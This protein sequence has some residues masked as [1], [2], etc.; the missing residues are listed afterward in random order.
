MSKK[1]FRFQKNSQGG[2]D[3][4]WKDDQGKLYIG[5]NKDTA[6]P[7]STLYSF[8]HATTRD[9]YRDGKPVWKL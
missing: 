8:G 9:Y 5:D 3:T 6:S 2:Y 4:V 7:A 1:I